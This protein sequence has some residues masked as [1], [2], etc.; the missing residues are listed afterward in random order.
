MFFEALRNICYV[1]S[2]LLVRVLHLHIGA[3]ATP[4][5]IPDNFELRAEVFGLCAI[6]VAEDGLDWNM[7]ILH[8]SPLAQ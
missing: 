2:V 5:L 7:R 3:S 8:H 6:L 1:K 4:K